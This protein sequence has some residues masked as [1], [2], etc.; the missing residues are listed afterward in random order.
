MSVNAY[1]QQLG[2]SQ[3]DECDGQ[4][5]PSAGTEGEVAICLAAT[6]Q[7]GAPVIAEILFPAGPYI[8]LPVLPRPAFP[9]EIA[10]VGVHDHD[11]MSKSETESTD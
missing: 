4:P 2:I 9:L 5:T 11:Q 1:L 3:P 6:S 10:E 7:V 8:G